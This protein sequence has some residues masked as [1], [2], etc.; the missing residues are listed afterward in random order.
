MPRGRWRRMWARSPRCSPRKRRS[1]PIACV[2]S[3]CCSQNMCR[4]EKTGG[5]SSEMPGSPTP[6]RL[7]PNLNQYKRRRRCG[8][9]P[10][11]C[12]RCSLGLEHLDG[13]D[14][15][16]AHSLEGLGQ[17]GDFVATGGHKVGSVEIAETDLVGHLGELVHRTRDQ[18]EQHHV[19][20]EN[21]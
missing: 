6:R 1:G 21:E 11:A 16:L 4:T 18:V 17:I 14:Q 9:A 19:E 8:D 20:S 15:A 12:D 5:N 2:P 7:P 3:T 13:L 10:R